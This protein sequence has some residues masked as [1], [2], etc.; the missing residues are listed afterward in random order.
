MA[1]VATPVSVP[2]EK[3]IDATPGVPEAQLPLA[4]ASLRLYVSPVHMVLGPEMATGK[5]LTVTN[6]VV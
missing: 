6:E 5:G 4:V 1:P 2:V 3:T